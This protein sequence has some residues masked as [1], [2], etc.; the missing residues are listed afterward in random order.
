M[1]MELTIKYGV[2]LYTNALSDGDNRGRGED[3][4][5]GTKTDIDGNPIVP[6]SGRNPSIANNQ[7]KY[8]YQ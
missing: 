2:K 7:A 6:G 5:I 8:G 4:D 3:A 1:V